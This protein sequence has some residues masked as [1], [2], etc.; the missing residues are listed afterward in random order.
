MIDFKGNHGCLSK[1]NRKYSP[2]VSVCL[3]TLLN[4]MCFISCLNGQEFIGQER[5]KL[6]LEKDK[7]STFNNI[8]KKYSVNDTSLNFQIPEATVS[9]KFELVTDKLTLIG[10]DI[11]QSIELNRLPEIVVLK[12][13]SSAYPFNRL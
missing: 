4:H 1:L 13:G 8:T 11:A 10:G 3:F 5:K 2:N 9:Y 7:Q 6:E 12:V